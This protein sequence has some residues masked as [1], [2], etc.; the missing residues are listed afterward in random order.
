MNKQCRIKYFPVSIFSIVFGLLGLTIVFEKLEEIWGSNGSFAETLLLISAVVLGIFSLA[1]LAKTIFYFGEVKKE[2]NH[3]I[4]LA[5]F[6]ALSVSFLLL[7]IAILE[8]FPLW[9]KYSLWIGATLQLIFTIKIISLWINH[10]KFK[11]DHLNPAWFIPILGNVLVPI[12][13]MHFGYT[14]ISLFFFS[15]GFW[16][17]IIVMTLFFNRIIFHGQMAERFV[18]TLFILISPP[19][20][21][22]IAWSKISGGVDVFGE[23]LYFFGL[24]LFM[25][26]LSQIKEFLKVKF[27]LSSW[28]YTFPIASM[29][30]ATILMYHGTK[31]ENYKYL[32]Y[33]FTI[34]LVLLVI[35][36][37]QKTFKA[38]Q[39]REIC[40]DEDH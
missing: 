12:S 27:Y 22:F 4:K 33:I 21:A 10:P 3:P 1:Y 13:A 37:G 20:I 40:I 19:F 5:F 29:T 7:S 18:P 35:I 31:I 39:K 16:F 2:F 15:I 9:A 14:E 23:I 17:W 24:F 38:I 36:L 8:F 32:A 28:A 26:L 30:I 25:I 11:L 34:F 6:P